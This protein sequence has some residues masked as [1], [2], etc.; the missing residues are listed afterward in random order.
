V[1]VCCVVDAEKER[2]GKR[3]RGAAAI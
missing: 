3:A 1:G 2:E